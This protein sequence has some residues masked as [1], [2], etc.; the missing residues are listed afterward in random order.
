[1]DVEMAALAVVVGLAVVVEEEEES[2]ME[3]LLIGDSKPHKVLLLDHQVRSL[4]LFF[5]KYLSN[6]NAVDQLFH[7]TMVI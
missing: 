4:P 7:V 3:E 1:M 5:F 6:H 2:M